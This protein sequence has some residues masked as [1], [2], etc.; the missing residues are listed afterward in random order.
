MPERLVK[1]ILYS[2]IT[3]AV[4]FV[5]GL[6]VFQIIKPNPSCF[7]HRKN[8]G[9][10][11]IDCG[12]LCQSCEIKDLLALE[13]E[14]K[15][16]GFLQ[17]N[18]YFLYNQIVNRNDDW[19]LKEFTYSFNFVKEV[20]NK[21]KIKEEIIKKV[22]GKSYILP[23]QVKYLVE[24]IE[25]PDFTY[26]KIILN[27]DTKKMVWA[28]PLSPDF[29]EAN[30][31][32]V[33]NVVL[34]TG[35]GQI[36]SEANNSTSSINYN[37]TKDIKRGNQ[38]EDVFNL[39]SILAQNPA[40]YPEGI[41]N[42]IFDLPTYKA[43]IRFQKLI[44]ISPQT[45]IV[46]YKTREYLNRTYGTGGQDT[47]STSGFTFNTNLKFGDIGSEVSE[48]QRVLK[49]YPA[50]YPEGRLTG[51]FDYLLKKA[52]ERFQT[53]YSLQVTGEFDTPT[54]TQLNNLINKS[55]SSEN[56]I[57]PGVTA[58][59][60]FNVFNNVNASWKEIL[61]VGF[62]CDQEQNLVAV[63]QTTN[64]IM[65]QNSQTVALSWTHQLPASIAICPGGLNVYT[66][67]MDENNV[68]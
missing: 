14:P 56:D 23:K 43:V 57:P 3:I 37:F 10:E 44:G 52:I 16:A 60:A 19:G 33:S 53:Q 8:N 45:G 25:K 39:Q 46:D 50:I 55:N 47:T 68:K 42:G 20:E 38:G 13:Y 4:I 27:I 63:A 9:E 54:R 64:E 6:V 2:L 48:L 22:E 66:N 67:T 58:H 35:S 34:K 51:K 15:S 1:Q 32:S 61:T 17:N 36:V 5:T 28:K 11:G 24:M 65:A 21:G 7:D 40:V 41:V 59:L 26:D 62:L 31:F 30:L 29:V 12:G 49:E 18:N